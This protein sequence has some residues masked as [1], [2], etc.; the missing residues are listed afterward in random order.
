LT[1][2]GGLNGGIAVERKKVCKKRG[3]WKANVARRIVGR[4]VSGLSRRFSLPEGDDVSD[5]ANDDMN[6][7]GGGGGS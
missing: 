5:D 7:G 6:G 1:T 4:N 3:V 2:Q